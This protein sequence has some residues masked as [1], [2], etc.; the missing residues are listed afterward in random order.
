MHVSALAAALAF[1]G[2]T[3]ARIPVHGLPSHIN[4]HTVTGH[5]ATP[6]ITNIVFHRPPGK[7]ATTITSLEQAFVTQIV[8]MPGQVVDARP[9][10]IPKVADVVACAAAATVTQ[11]VTGYVQSH[12]LQSHPM[13][14]NPA[15]TPVAGSVM[16]HLEGLPW[17]YVSSSTSPIA[18]I[19]PLLSCCMFSFP[20]LH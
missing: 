6:A 16:D 9:R 8:S 20:D 13:Q 19:M 10:E 3:T 7:R 4:H 18:Q 1:I 12:P 2:S 15:P 14:S 17:Q 5:M 11:T